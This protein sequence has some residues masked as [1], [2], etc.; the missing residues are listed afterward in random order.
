MIMDKIK[1]TDI[2]IEEINEY[3]KKA[4]VCVPPVEKPE[5]VTEE[6]MI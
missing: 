2:R 4:E 1:R 6:E 5:D 3:P